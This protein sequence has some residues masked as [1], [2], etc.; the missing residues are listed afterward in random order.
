MSSSFVHSL[1]LEESNLLSPANSVKVTDALDK[2]AQILEGLIEKK[3]SPDSSF[4]DSSLP[5]VRSFQEAKNYKLQC[6][7]YMKTLALRAK[8]NIIPHEKR[9]MLDY[10]FRKLQRLFDQIPLQYT[11]AANVSFNY[12]CLN[13]TDLLSSQAAGVC[14]SLN[15]WVKTA[16]RDGFKEIKCDR[17]R[18][19]EKR[20]I[21]TLNSRLQII[22]YQKDLIDKMMRLAARAIIAIRGR[23]TYDYKYDWYYIHPLDLKYQTLLCLLDEAGDLFN[24][25][26]DST[27]AFVGEFTILSTKGSAKH[28]FKL[29]IAARANRWQTIKQLRELEADS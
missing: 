9:V 1:G 28:S 14:L 13:C 27:Q 18:S 8:D 5:L 23:K 26:Q 6:L 16:I 21:A 20:K 19:L 17:I 7:K 15:S 24:P 10:R 29:L 25:A 3:V 4:N 11:G 22:L 12:L 2:A